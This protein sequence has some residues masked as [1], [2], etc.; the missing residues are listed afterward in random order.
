MILRRM[1]SE[2]PD[3]DETI[4]P[5]PATALPRSLH[6]R[7]PLRLRVF[8]EGRATQAARGE[9]VKTSSSARSTALRSET[10]CLPTDRISR[11]VILDASR[12]PSQTIAY[13]SSSSLGVPRAFL[14]SSRASRSPQRSSG[15]LSP[16]GRVGPPAAALP[17]GRRRTLDGRGVT[18]RPG[19]ENGARPSARV[20]VSPGYRPRSSL[21]SSMPSPGPCV[22]TASARPDRASAAVNH[23]ASQTRPILELEVDPA[24]NRRSPL[25]FSSRCRSEGRSGSVALERPLGSP[26][27]DPNEVPQRPTLFR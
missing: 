2:T 27:G 11:T 7:R 3:V 13:R 25:S 23:I 12:P 6:V 14:R 20:V 8:T 9:W 26:Q 21:A 1:S 16:F 10:T 24:F 22:I 18:S 19:A 15:A 5:W 4:G 17:F